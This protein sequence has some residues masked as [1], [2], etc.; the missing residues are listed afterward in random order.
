MD[1]EQ[2]PQQETAAP[3]PKVETSSN[4][5]KWI[6]IGVIAVALILLGQL[7][8]PERMSERFIENALEDAYDID[9]DV[10]RNGNVEYTTE[11]EEGTVHMSAGDNVALP[12][13]WPDSVPLL[14]DAKITYAGT[15]GADASFTSLTVSY[16]TGRSTSDVT[17]FYADAVASNGWTLA[18][19][20]ATPEATVLS[21]TRG[22]D[23]STVVYISKSDAGTAVT[24][25]AQVKK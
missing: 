19:N 17:A 7:F 9:V 12:K 21:A 24:L 2:S 1:Q 8:S 18:S 25:T 15:V 16:E 13:G 23:E 4:K 11:T 10:D 14:P 22:E 6:I 20:M 3:S 5:T